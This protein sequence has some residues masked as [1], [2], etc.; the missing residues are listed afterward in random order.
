MTSENITEITN[1]LYSLTQYEI[2][3]SFIVSQALTNTRNQILRENLLKIREETEKDIDKLSLL[4]EQYGKK[5]PEHSV[6]FKG[7][8]M[9]GYVGMRGFISDQGILKALHTNMQIIMNAFEK[10]LEDSLSEEVKEKIRS[11]Q[12]NSRQHLNYFAAQI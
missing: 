6:D 9:Q 3:K 2:D 7:F 10:A 8:F 5:P 12:E 4:L 1:V 11:V